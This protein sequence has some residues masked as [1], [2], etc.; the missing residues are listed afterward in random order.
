MPK[1]N[2]E[3]R[4]FPPG[5][6]PL[7]VLSGLLGR[8]TDED[9]RIL[10]GPRVGEDATIID[11]GD[12]C[13]VAKTDPITFATDDIGH[14]AVHVNANDIAT[15]GAVPKWFLASL[16]LPEASTDERL[17]ET[18][19]ESTHRAAKE[20]GVAFCGGH[21]EITVGLDRPILVGQMLGEVKREDIVRSS[22]LEVGDAVLLTKGLGVEATSIIAREKG[23]ELTSQGIDSDRLDA[24]RDYLY[25]PGISVLTEARIACST[26]RVHA[27]HDPTEGGVATALRE[28]ALAADVGLMVDGDSLFLSDLTKALCVAFGL[29]PLGVISSGALL[30]G[31]AGED[32]ER[33]RDAI[34]S[35]DIACEV[36][37]KAEAPGYGVKMRE[38]GRLVDLPSFDRDEI[39]KLFG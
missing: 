20:A 18:I 25:D 13:L 37:A 34:R 21:T 7:D 30:I 16:L 29:D 10:I 11:F 35:E 28:L 15:M 32:S 31:V 22:G 26:T 33:V 1:P 17:V 24:A 4:S 2:A 9:D 19:F 23:D 3:R 6:L 36:I 12:T 8:F 27:M 5:K 14:Y 38:S 39:G